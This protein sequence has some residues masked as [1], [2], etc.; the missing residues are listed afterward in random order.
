V[1]QQDVAEWKAS[2]APAIERE[3]P[4]RGFFCKTTPEYTNKGWSKM[5]I[6]QKELNFMNVAE[7]LCENATKIHFG[8]VSVTLKIHNGQVVS[9]THTTSES[10][11]ENLEDK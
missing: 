1:R 7:R 10:I 11:R 9:I 3:S 8:L 5:T 6:N 4:K 2:P